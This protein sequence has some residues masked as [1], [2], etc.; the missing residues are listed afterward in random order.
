[1][2]FD[3]RQLRYAIFAADHGS[4]YRAARAL[5][6]EQS[7]LSRAILRLER[8]L[9]AELFI[10]SRAGVSPTDA[11]LHFL[12]GA[13]TMLA[14]ADRMVEVSRAVG[15]GKAGVLT[16]G[17]NSSVSAGHL[18][19]TLIE[20]QK[21]SPDLV[22]EG[23]EADRN[24]LFA[25]LDSNAVD[26]AILLGEVERC[27]YLHATFWSERVFVALASDHL[28]AARDIVH[29]T[30]L[31]DQ[32][33]VLPAADPGP[34]IR[35]MLLGRLWKSG[36]DTSI[37]LHAVS[38]EAVLSMIGETDFLS[39][40]CEGSTGT[41]FPKLVYRPVHGEQGPAL[42]TYSGYWR[43]NNGNPAL[44]RFLDLVRRRYALSFGHRGE[45]DGSQ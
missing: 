2:S 18:R 16:I 1:M 41:Q 26:I 4:F 3:I 42:I 44:K 13:R 27:E 37:A 5:N 24:T 15:L 14:S 9:G 28:L 21:V 7:T 25:G 8:T 29:W 6:I 34:D 10:R 31:R 32:R 22:I 35:D 19:A 40:V 12:R 39:I 23:M 17:F 38:R 43:E 33:F 20:A 30:D 45:E 36:A 11:G